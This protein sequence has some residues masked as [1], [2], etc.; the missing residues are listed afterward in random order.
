MQEC[1]YNSQDVEDY[2]HHNSEILVLFLFNLPTI[3]FMLMYISWKVLFINNDLLY[4]Q[5]CGID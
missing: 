3:G 2:T 5:I 1:A 4:I